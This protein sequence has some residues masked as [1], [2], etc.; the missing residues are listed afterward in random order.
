MFR[1]GV[2]WKIVSPLHLQIAFT[3]NGCGSICLFVY[4]SRK[5]LFWTIL[6]IRYFDTLLF[7]KWNSQNEVITKFNYDQSSNRAHKIKI[8]FFK[9]VQQSVLFR[10]FFIIIPTG[11]ARVSVSNFTF[12]KH[13]YTWHFVINWENWEKIWFCRD[14]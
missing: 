1:W 4:C 12:S 6:N 8:F 14:Y 3:W 10:L 11:S 2:K 5:W 9:I 7:E 13:Y